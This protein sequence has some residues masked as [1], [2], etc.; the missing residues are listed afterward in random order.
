MSISKRPSPLE[1]RISIGRLGW[2]VNSCNRH[3][4]VTCN[5]FS[6]QSAVLMITLCFFLYSES[7]P[8][9]LLQKGAADFYIVDRLSAT[10]PVWE[11][12]L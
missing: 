7:V 1:M 12:T 3:G 10:N 6:Q 4:Q 2:G 11:C 8:C 5:G 9:V